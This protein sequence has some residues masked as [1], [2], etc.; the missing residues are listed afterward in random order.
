MGRIVAIASSSP[1]QAVNK[2]EPALP[3]PETRFMVA[4]HKQ[5]RRRSQQGFGW[6]EKIIS[7]SVPTITPSCTGTACAPVW[8]RTF[9]I[10]NVTNVNHQIRLQLG[11][12]FGNF[13]KGPFV[14]IVA[15]LK[16]IF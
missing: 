12:T 10:M 1:R 7:P 13:G 2:T 9:T 11:C 14:C 6:L 3:C 15:I 5:P 16:S 8:T 4:T